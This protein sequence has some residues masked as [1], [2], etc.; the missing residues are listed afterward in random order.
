MTTP[1]FDVDLVTKA[2]RI[3]STLLLVSPSVWY[4]DATS[5]STSTAAPATTTAAS[6][7]ATSPPASHRPT[8]AWRPFCEL[9]RHTLLPDE[10]GAP[11]AEGRQEAANASSA[12]VL[13]LSKR[14][15]DLLTA[16][17]KYFAAAAG[18]EAR[19]CRCGR[20]LSP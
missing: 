6:S 17:P 18:E 12:L 13:D 20:S 4:D 1:P 7:S 15:R 14:M 8:L 16:V 3:L 11:E 2:A 9:L 5:N 10:L 19:V